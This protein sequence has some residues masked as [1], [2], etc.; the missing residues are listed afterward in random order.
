MYVLGG[1]LSV[2]L[3]RLLFRFECWAFKG[4]LVCFF[5]CLNLGFEDHFF[6]TNVVK[7]T[8]IQMQ[9]YAIVF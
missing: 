5:C 3:Y 1:K 6:D 2:D 7:F 8:V 4:L 9:L